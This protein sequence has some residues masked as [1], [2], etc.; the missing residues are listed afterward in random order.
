MAVTLVVGVQW[1]DEGKGRIVD[2]LASGAE[3]VA[4]F[5]GGANAGHTVRVGDTTYKLRIVPSGV[6]AGVNHCIIGP[7]TAVSP[8]QF[9]EELR[10]LTAADVDV[11]RIW[12]SDLAHLI[13]PYHIEQDKAAERARGA[14]AIGTTGNGIG[15]SYVDRAA[16]RGLRAGDLRDMRKCRDHITQRCGQLIREGIHADA[17]AIVGDLE[18]Q[19]KTILPHVRD[20]VSLLNDALRA[21]KQV[22]AEGAQGSLLDVTFGMYPYVTSSVTVAGGA[23]A[24][25]GFGPTAVDHVIGVVKAYSTRVGAGP[26]PTELHDATGE[27]LRE[28]GAEFGTVTGRARR[29]GW[30]DAVALRYAAEI[31]GLSHLAITKL[32]ILDGFD[33]IAMC[34][35]YETSAVGSLPFIV[36]ANP[37]PVYKR[38]AGWSESTTGARTFGELPAHAQAY[39]AALE[40]AVGVPVAY[41]SV[42]PERSQ[43]IVRD[44][45]PLPA[46]A[47][48]I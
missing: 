2:Y 28:R 46:R 13:L 35:A 3:I 8:G 33:E 9:V 26:F 17:A 16:R 15:P 23:G 11:S 7:G 31:N 30:L 10:A 12:L 29:C 21:G 5:G 14:A 32:D 18:L 44:N 24:G 34:D 38:F 19:A 39:I 27:R 48:H 43:I 42:G 6:L 1:G 22:I 36:D 45:A 4:R 37:K 40:R 20:T 25:L 41:I 47:P